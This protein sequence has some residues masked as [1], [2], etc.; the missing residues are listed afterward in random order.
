MRRPLHLLCPLPA[1]DAALQ[2]STLANAAAGPTGIPL[3][4]PIGMPQ[5]TCS[6]EVRLWPQ[7]RPDHSNNCGLK[8]VPAPCTASPPVPQIIKSAKLEEIRITIL[9]NLLAFHPESGEQL[10]WGTPAARA[11]E[12]RACPRHKQGRQ[13]SLH[14]PH[15]G[16]K[17]RPGS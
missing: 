4:P 11:G 8:H 15:R 7:A 2:G 12:Q 14:G 6:W 9:Q 3:V 1:A 17:Q 10:A 5:P 16:L 13:P